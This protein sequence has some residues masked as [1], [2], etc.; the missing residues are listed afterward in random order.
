MKLYFC[1]LV[2]L[3]FQACTKD[4][5]SPS[6]IDVVHLAGIVANPSGKTVASYWK[7]GVYARLTKTDSASEVDCMAVSGSNVWIGGWDWSLLPNTAVVWKNGE[8]VSFNC[9]GE[10]YATAAQGSDLYETHFDNT[11]RCWVYSK[12]GVATAIADTALSI[13]PTGIALQG[14]DVFISGGSLVS[15]GT[16]SVQH[17]EYW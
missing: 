17:A 8:Q 7:D 9:P 2:T 16:H 6:T 3:V 5:Q 10:I 14:N 11:N 12:N 1:L 13:Q 15:S 4:V